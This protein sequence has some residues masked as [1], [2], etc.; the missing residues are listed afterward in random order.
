MSLRDQNLDPSLDEIESMAAITA[1]VWLAEMVGI[2]A[3]EGIAD[4]A[5]PA[6]IAGGLHAMAIFYQAERQVDAADRIRDGL[7]AVA[8]QLQA[9]HQPK[10]VDHAADTAVALQSIAKAFQRGVAVLELFAP[11]HFKDKPARFEG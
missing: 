10:A 9:L 4:K 3:E 6:V 11:V 2:C 1:H 8:D 5:Y 7:L